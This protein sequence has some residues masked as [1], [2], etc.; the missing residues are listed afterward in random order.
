MSGFFNPISMP[1]GVTKVHGARP[2]C[3]KKHLSKQMFHFTHPCYVAVIES[4]YLILVNKI[5]SCKCSSSHFNIHAEAQ[6]RGRKV[7]QGL[8]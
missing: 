5:V 1:T 7:V 8:S 3:W 4:L 2:K 6:R